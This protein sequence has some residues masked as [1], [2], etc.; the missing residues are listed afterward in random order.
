[1]QAK[2]Y[3]VR[4]NKI[5]DM[6]QSH[7]RY[8]ID[9]SEAFGLTKDYVE[10]VYAKYNESLGVEG[11]AREELIKRVSSNGWV[12]VRHYVGKRDYWSIQC[13]DIDKRIKTIK[14]F[15]EH[16]VYVEEEMRQD[17]ELQIL[18]YTTNE[19]RKYSFQEGGAHTFITENKNVDKMD[20]IVEEYSMAFIR[21]MSEDLL[22]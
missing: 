2:G 21:K 3:W 4:G 1:M 6:G 11:K 9:N 17:D 19:L 15:V 12:R 5:L 7:I 20:M 10:D 16:M 13:D 8:V 18:G 22:Q 14:N